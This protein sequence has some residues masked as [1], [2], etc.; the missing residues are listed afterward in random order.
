MSDSESPN[1][2]AFHPQFETLGQRRGLRVTDPVEDVQFSL[3]TP[4]H[5]SLTACSTDAAPWCFPVDSAVRIPTNELS[6]PLRVN[7]NVRTPD[8]TLV[9]SVA[10]KSPGS[11]DDVGAYVVELSSTPMKLYLAAESRVLVLPDD[12]STELVFPDADAVHL[13]ARTRHKHPARTLTTT[14]DP[15][16][17]MEV[18]SEF[19]AALKTTSC[20]RS[21]PTLRGHPPVIEFG[22][23]VEIPGGTRRPD[24][25]VAIEVPPT[26]EKIFPVAPL[27][28]YLGA[29]VRPGA[30]PRLVTASGFSYDLTGAGGFERTVGEVLKHVF[31]L[32]CLTRVEGYYPVDLHERQRAA[33]IPSLD[34]EFAAL[35]E[36]PLAEQL[37]TYLSV[38]LEDVEPLRPEWR[39]T[40][41]VVP[42]L[43]HATV[44]PYL[45]DELAIL[46]CAEYGTA[47]ASVEATSG[48][49]ASN[50]AVSDFCRSSPA[51]T[52]A[53]EPSPVVTDAADD[54][55]RGAGHTDAV[56]GAADETSFGAAPGRHNSV[57]Q[58]DV[59]YVDDADSATQTYVGDGFPIGA[60]KSSRASYER[61]LTLRS[62]AP[63]RISV[64]V[65]CNDGEM[66]EELEVGNYYGMRDLL[67]FEVDI[68]QNL[69]REELRGVFES[70][71]DFVHYI[72]HVTADGLQASD[73]YLDAGTLDDVGVS[74][75][76]LNGCR[77]FRQGKRLVDAGAIGGIVT[78][79]NIHNSIA[80]EI[81][82]HISR[83]LNAGWPL[84]GALK[85]VKD[86]ALAG[87]HYLVVGDGSTEIVNADGGTPNSLVIS[88]YDDDRYKVEFNTFPT[89]SFNLGT[90][91]NPFLQ[92]SDTHYLSSGKLDEFLLP[93]EELQE[94]CAH[95]SLPLQFASELDETT[96]SIRWSDEIEL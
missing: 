37:E 6:I 78:L 12:N 32:D 44:L 11:V 18:I 92:E 4:E 77:S 41:D 84:D 60:N 7:V 70:G 22:D 88:A 91:D 43:E 34:L 24:T 23:E 56:R 20:E 74:A 25:G 96:I 19:G 3:F 76:F 39:L 85:L 53:A 21:W 42:E 52:S 36:Q 64:T 83:L 26:P 94:F 48:E 68:Q 67:E 33:E 50:G 82:H 87:R 80:T 63:D 46:R 31:T 8:A 27:A 75:F 9:E 29:E 81:G 30:S 73:G 58:D 28:Y 79:E 49:P 61:Q 2:T 72:G 55:V 15:H 38:P 54:F 17:L 71:S 65:V 69:T 47:T 13:G 86:D 95:Y 35:Y 10:A 14:R 16:D 89:Q 62:N 93:T 45:A 1:G 66:L 5:V 59:F 57:S 90:I 51:E 40:A